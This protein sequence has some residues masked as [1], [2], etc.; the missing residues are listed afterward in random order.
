L[1]PIACIQTSA[2]YGLSDSIR[3]LGGEPRRTF[4]A[5]GVDPAHFDDLILPL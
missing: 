1:T 2:G 4:A 5:A 3:S